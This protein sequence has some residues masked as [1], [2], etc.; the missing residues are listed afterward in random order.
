MITEEMRNR[1]R[2]L[3]QNST[4]FEQTFWKS[5]RAKRFSGYKFRRQQTIG[6]Y[7]VDFVCF[8]AKLIVELDG[9]QHVERADY[10]RQRDDWL[11][12]QGYRVFRIWNHEWVRQKNIVLEE[13]W[14]A[15]Q[16]PSFSNT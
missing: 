9:S 16:S 14:N 3:R 13:I 15:L 5:V 8:Q 12:L 1:A 7:I 11:R 6:P 10:D 4:S 2:Q